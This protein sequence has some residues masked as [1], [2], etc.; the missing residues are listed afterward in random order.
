MTKTKFTY[1]SGVENIGPGMI[2]HIYGSSY[3]IEA[4][5]VIP[6]GGAEGAIVANADSLGGFSLYVQNGKLHHTYSFL[7]IPS[8]E[9]KPHPKLVIFLEHIGATNAIFHG[10]AKGWTISSPDRCR[11]VR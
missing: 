3:A 5:L 9:E 8:T 6:A 2:P 10:I 7:G 1:Y 11:P 4:D